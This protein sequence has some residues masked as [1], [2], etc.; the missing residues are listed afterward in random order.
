MKI[1]IISLLPE[2]FG[3]LINYGVLSKAFSSQDNQTQKIIFEFINPR[4]F[5][6][7]THKTIDDRPFGGGPGMLMLA[8]PLAQSIE[9][10]KTKLP[11]AP[12]IYLSPQGEVFSQK[13]AE[14]FSKDLIHK[15]SGL[16]FLC[17]RYEGI[18]QRVIDLLV[19]QEVSLGDFVLSGGELAL[20]CLL[21]AVVRL[22][23]GILG[24]EKSALE[25]SFSNPEGLLDCPHYT[26]PPIWRGL[27]VPEVLLSGHHENIKKWRAQ[28]A[29]KNTERK[30][31]DL[32]KNFKNK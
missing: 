15:N 9:L 22:I 8:E 4:D 6:S 26:R 2:M 25:D 23:P 17:G 14:N 27:A 13:M 18:D 32:L 1:I 3:S 29:L 19:D 31:P 28:E 16:I 7:N 24:D 5:V 11:E 12:V 21:D 30:R 10:A 20:M